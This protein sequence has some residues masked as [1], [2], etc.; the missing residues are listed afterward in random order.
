MFGY[1][2]LLKH[3]TRDCVYNGSKYF[4]RMTD[5]VDVCLEYDEASDDSDISVGSK[6][7]SVLYIKM[8]Y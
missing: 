4:Q 6:R 5:N 7:Q 2:V 3:T 8:F 1:S